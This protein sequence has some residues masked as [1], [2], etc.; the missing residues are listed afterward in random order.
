MGH[1]EVGV[2]PPSDEPPGRSKL[3]PR[4]CPGKRRLLRYIPSME[5]RPEYPPSLQGLGPCSGQVSW[6]G[7]IPSSAK[8]SFGTGYSRGSCSS[9]GLTLH[10]P[11]TCFSAPPPIYSAYTSEHTPQL[12]LLVSSPHPVSHHILPVAPPNISQSIHILHTHYPGVI[13][14]HLNY[15]AGTSL[16]PLRLPT[17]AILYTVDKRK[18]LKF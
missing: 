9:R 7:P 16:F 17:Q 6:E 2:W 11:Q 3:P 13:I 8:A 10:P 14:S 1:P 15:A 4:P 5:V 12:P 18:I